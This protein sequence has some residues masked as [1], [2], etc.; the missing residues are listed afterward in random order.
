VSS[1]ITA[2]I[3]AASAVCLGSA[4]MI[5]PG[6][7]AP[8]HAAPGDGGQ[9]AD[10]PIV[11]FASVGMSDTL[12][13][14]GVQGTQNLTFPVPP[15]LVPAALNAVVEL[16]PN[17]RAGVITVSQGDRTLSRVDLPGTDRTP[18]SI[19]LDGAQ[20]EGNAI[21][22]MVRSQLVPPAEYCLYDGVNPLRLVNAEIAF[23][24][25]ELPPRVVADFLPPVLQRVSI[26]VPPNPSRAESDAAVRLTTAIVARYG[27]QTTDVDLVA[28]SGDQTAPPVPSQP[29]ERQIVIKEGPTPSVS[30]EGTDGVP[31]LL[32]TGSGND[33]A[34]QTRLLSSNM[35]QLAL[36]SKAVAGPIKSSPQLPANQTTIRELGQPGVNATALEPQVSIGL[37]QTR[38]GRPVRDVRVHLKGAYTPL[39]SS[40]G[41]QVVASVAGQAVDRWPVEASG[42]ID[43]WISIP[44]DQLTRY[45]N[46][47]VAIDLSGNTGR[48]GEFQPVKLTIDGATAIDSVDA[49]PPVTHGF[50]SLPQALMPRTTIGIG[51]DA[52]AD[53]AR[54][55]TIMEGLQRLGNLPL[56][57]NVVSLEDAESG[58]GPTL[59]ISADQWTDNR[60]K[61]PV[62]TTGDGDLS[63]VPVGGGDAT[64]LKLDPGLRFG[65]LQTLVDGDRTV[66]IATSNGSAGQLDSLL[67]WLDADPKRW[68]ALKG[69]ALLAAPDR[70]PLTFDAGTPSADQQAKSSGVG[71]VVWVS[72]AAVAVVVIAVGGW[73]LARRRRNA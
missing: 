57:T 68:S 60:L 47:D 27:Q 30:L 36:A 70:E 28:L 25:Q 34:N 20:I 65:S 56:D 50:Q 29:F 48:C 46:L 54:A 26:F 2:A 23:M 10:S 59:L 41:G 72:V 44:N 35:A 58:T 3:R 5:L 16:P 15:G 4:L 39:P 73:L 17:V 32:I 21:S 66:V 61:L 53:T 14:Y 33:L 51:T 40:V 62:G 52:F 11:R 13:L 19:P 1:R 12:S 69:D 49:H 64:T 42:T 55:V 45:T 6:A 63:V 31:A 38:L 24:G 71:A 37:D 43:R 18:I 7:V 67:N 22:V 8:V 9:V